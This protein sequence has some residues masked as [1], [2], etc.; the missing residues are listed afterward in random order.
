MLVMIPHD[1]ALAAIVGELGLAAC[2]HAGATP[3]SPSRPVTYASLWE[4]VADSNMRGR[5]ANYSSL[6]Y[7][8]QLLEAVKLWK[9]E[10]V[11]FFRHYSCRQYSIFPIKAK[12]IIEEELGIP[13]LNLEGDY[14]DYRSYNVQQ[15]RTRL[16]T[17]AEMV[18]SGRATRERNK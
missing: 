5:G 7:I 16:E 3:R 1:P 8:L 6:A 9:V 12:E 13:V 14:C 10:G 17:F 4:D 2:V 18:K 15:M 11:I